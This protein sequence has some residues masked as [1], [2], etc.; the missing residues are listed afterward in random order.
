MKDKYK[1]ISKTP[2]FPMS[3]P[4]TRVGSYECSSCGNTHYWNGRKWN[5]RGQSWGTNSPYLELSEWRG[6]VRSA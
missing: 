5:V 2:W 4:P 3:T 1:G 6:L